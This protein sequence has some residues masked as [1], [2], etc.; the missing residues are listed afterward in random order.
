MPL[1]I[2]GNGT[3]LN[4]PGTTAYPN[5]TGDNRVLGG[6]GP[7]QLYFDPSVYSLPAAGVQGNMKRNWRAR[8]TWLLGTRQLAVQAVRVGGFALCRDSASMPTT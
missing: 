5:L 2:T 3:L 8:G 7:G 4:T 6:L 1:N